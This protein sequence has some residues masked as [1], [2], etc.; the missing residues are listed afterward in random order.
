MTDPNEFERSLESRLQAHAERAARPFDAGSIAMRAA[1]TTPPTQLTSFPVR[2]R[3]LLPAAIGLLLT[4]LIGGA[5]LSGRRPTLPAV[6]DP[7]P[8]S[9]AESRSPA[10]SPTRAKPSASTRPLVEELGRSRVGQL[11]Q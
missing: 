7:V 10:P 11:S 8:P 1:T 2:P 3:W 6:V 4:V 9:P 5:L